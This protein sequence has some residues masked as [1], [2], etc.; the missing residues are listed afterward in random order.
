MNYRG[1]KRLDHTIPT[2]AEWD[3]RISEAASF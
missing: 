2:F 1:R 3:G